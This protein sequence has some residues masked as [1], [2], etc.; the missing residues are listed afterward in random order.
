MKIMFS[1]IQY[2]QMVIIM[3]SCS[4][5]SLGWDCWQT[6]L[7][8][9]L[10]HTRSTVAEEHKSLSFLL[11]KINSETCLSPTLPS[12]S[13]QH[14]VCLYSFTFIVKPSGKSQ[15]ESIHFWSAGGP[16]RLLNTATICWFP[17]QTPSPCC[18]I[19]H[20]HEGVFM[21]IPNCWPH[22]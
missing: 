12:W 16:R 9:H 1:N 6:L 5:Y 7:Q 15:Y 22:V 20:N 3:S 13:L 2:L 10:V 4:E 11:W 18:Y 21:A 14:A 19:S 17:V 8:T